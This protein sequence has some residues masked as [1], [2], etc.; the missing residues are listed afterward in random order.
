MRSFDNQTLG[1]DEIAIRLETN[2]AVDVGR[3]LRF[4]ECLA[5]HSGEDELLPPY[6]LQIVEFSKGSIFG[7]FLIDWRKEIDDARLARMEAALEKLRAQQHH[8]STR[9]ADAA[10]RQAN[11]AEVQTGLQHKGLVWTRVG[12]GI[13]A[14]TLVCTFGGAI[15]DEQP[16][17]CAT[18]VADLMEQDGV[19]RVQ[20]WSRDCTVNIEKRDVPEMQRREQGIRAATG[21]SEATS[22]TRFKSAEIPFPDA[23]FGPSSVD[24]P[25]R[26]PE[27]TAEGAVPRQAGDGAA[28]LAIGTGRNYNEIGEF[29]IVGD[30]IF[31]YPDGGSGPAKPALFIPP[32]EFMIGEMQR[33]RVSGRHFVMPGDYDVIAGNDAFL[34]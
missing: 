9:S 6:R 12:V 19:T 30:L 14:V 27:D 17:S 5:D 34:L 8:T 21:R 10:E 24:A 31:F 1:V 32:N 20:M 29:R 15:R 16:N 3:F 2:R 25:P 18:A 26:R 4:F 28:S 13:A 7:R 33:Y 11:A 22:H 23:A